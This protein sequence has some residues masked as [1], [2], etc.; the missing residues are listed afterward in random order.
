MLPKTA[1]PTAL[2]IDRQNMLAPVTTPRRSHP[3]TDCTATMSE[4]DA[5]PSPMPVT[6][7]AKA[8]R[9]SPLFSVT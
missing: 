5:K 4:I 3:T 1:M 8:T 9:P 7:L 6:K 2:P